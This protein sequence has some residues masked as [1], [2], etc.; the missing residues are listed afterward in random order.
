MDDPAG[1]STEV[2]AILKSAI[3]TVHQGTGLADEESLRRAIEHARLAVQP[4][5]ND[6]LGLREL[7]S[8]LLSIELMTALDL[9]RARRDIASLVASLLPLAGDAGPAG[10]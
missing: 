3:E 8:E 6:S 7:L 10:A 2:R 9:P 1:V 5:C 4:H